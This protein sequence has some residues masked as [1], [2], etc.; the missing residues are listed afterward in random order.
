MD[1]KIPLEEFPALEQ[2]SDYKIK[3]EV[4]DAEFEV[5][6]L[7][8]SIDIKE[9]STSL[10]LEQIKCE[11]YLCGIQFHDKSELVKHL[12]TECL[13]KPFSCEICALRCLTKHQLN[14]HTKTHIGKSLNVLF[15]INRI[16][17]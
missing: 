7:H 13:E 8:H 2:S 3:Q 14:R 1:Q 12:E 6:E 5:D 4:E 15:T 10:E 16:S 9:E 17:E 11:C